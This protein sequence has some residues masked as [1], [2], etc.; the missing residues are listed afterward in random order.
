MP[1][2]GG[3]KNQL[4]KPRDREDQQEASSFGGKVQ[5]NKPR[6]K[7]ELVEPSALGDGDQLWMSDGR[8]DQPKSPCGGG[9]DQLIHTQQK[10]PD[11]TG[12]GAKGVSGEAATTTSDAFN[13]WEEAPP[14]WSEEHHLVDRLDRLVAAA[15]RA[16]NTATP[17]LS[18]LLAARPPPQL[19]AGF[20]SS[21]F[22]ADK[23]PAL[24]PEAGGTTAT[25]KRVKTSPPPPPFGVAARPTKVAHHPGVAE[26]ERLLARGA[27]ASGSQKVKAMAAFGGPMGQGTAEKVGHS[28]S[29]DTSLDSGQREKSPHT[30]QPQT[31]T[32]APA[33]TPLANQQPIAGLP[34]AN[35]NQHARSSSLSSGISSNSFSSFSVNGCP[36]NVPSTIPSSC[37][38]STRSDKCS[39]SVITSTTTSSFSLTSGLVLAGT[40]LRPPTVPVLSTPSPP[41]STAVLTASS[42]SP[43]R[44]RSRFRAVLCEIGQKVPQIGGN[45]H[46]GVAPP[47]PDYPIRP[48]ALSASAA[49]T[50]QVIK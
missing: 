31:L 7:E 9:K 39:S 2:K 11:S 4:I 1:P 48:P 45:G 26:L 17:L 30:R 3:G 41:L 37:T 28:N 15:G 50:N 33:V 36:S 43:S 14:R 20:S 34:P 5:L 29:S 22:S 40:V 13:Q 12:C 44:L 32:R 46:H 25:R 6:A 38:S 42:P 21:T 23:Q 24:F 49:A 10:H 47:A 8:E 16:D 27:A 18:A 35:Q 19:S